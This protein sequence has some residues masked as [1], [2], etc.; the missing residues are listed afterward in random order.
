MYR[1]AVTI[2]FSFLSLAIATNSS[3]LGQDPT[4]DIKQYY[5]RVGH[6]Y[7]GQALGAVVAKSAKHVAEINKLKAE[8]DLAALA[9]L[10]ATGAVKIVPPEVILEVTKIHESSDDYPG[11]CIEL[12]EL[13]GAK[14]GDVV[15]ML[16]LQLNNVLMKPADA[17]T[18][19]T[20]FVQAEGADPDAPAAPA[21]PVVRTWKAAEGNFSVVAEFVSVADGKVVLKRKSDGKELTVP[22]D[23]LSAED[24][25]WIK[26]QAK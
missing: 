23:K 19:K 15:Y 12:Q 18:A 11:G 6:K 7:S 26:E 2:L 13:M 5:P 8:V 10:V 3:A 25:K 21:V 20:V 1:L 9:Q 24:N 16:P 17:A 14:K 4:Q 22:L